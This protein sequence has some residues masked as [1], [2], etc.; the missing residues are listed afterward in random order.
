MAV[1]GLLIDT[2]MCAKREVNW[3]SVKA[4]F[5]ELDVNNYEVL[6]EVSS[7]KF[8]VNMVADW[9]W[10]QYFEIISVKWFMEMTRKVMDLV[11]RLVFHLWNMVD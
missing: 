9:D 4:V 11:R 2:D 3:N 8:L 5:T 10:V 6:L 1:Q 7:N